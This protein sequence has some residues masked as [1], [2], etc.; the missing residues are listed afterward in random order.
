MYHPGPKRV[1][2]EFRCLASRLCMA[3]FVE[4]VRRRL[5]VCGEGVVECAVAGLGWGAV[6]EGHSVGADSEGCVVL[7]TCTS[8]GLA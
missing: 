1:G 5:C 3:P 2:E 4:R 7:W 8:L 6:G